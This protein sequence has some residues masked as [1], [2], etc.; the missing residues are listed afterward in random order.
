MQVAT[1]N[2]PSGKL[3]RL[4]GRVEDN[5]VYGVQLSGDFFL[6]PPEKIESLEQALEG[7]VLDD[8][9]AVKEVLAYVLE[10]DN[11]TIEGFSIQDVAEL[12]EELGENI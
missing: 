2:A 3:I 11:I 1:R 7:F 6:A 12:L 10:R 9:E 8:Q 4:K 5:K